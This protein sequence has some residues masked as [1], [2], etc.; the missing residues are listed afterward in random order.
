MADDLWRLDA[1]ALGRLLRRR[2][3]SPVD[4]FEMARGR[5]ERI[6]P[7]LNAFVAL[8]RTA[9]AEAEVSE[10]RHRA[11]GPLGPLDGVPVSIKDNLLAAGMPA[12]WGSRL[13]K[14]FVPGT[15]EAPVANLRA[16]G[17]ILVGKTNVPEFTLEG[18]TANALF[19][20]T[21]NPWNPD[22]TPGGSSGGAVASVAAG[23]VPAAIG[24]DGGGSIR[25]PAGYTGLVGLKPSLGRVR[26]RGGFPPLLL[27]MEVAGGLTRSVRDAKVVFAAMAGLG[28]ASPGNTVVAGAPPPKH[29][30]LYVERFGAAPLDPLIAAACR[31]AAG[32]LS[33][34]GHDVR[35]GR[36]PFDLEP[37]DRVWAEIGQIG[38][39]ALFGRHP[40]ARAKASE[41]YVAMADLGAALPATRPSGILDALRAFRAAAAAAFEAV[42]VVMTPASAAMPWPVSEPYPATIDG[43]AVG[44]RGHAVYTGW[45]NAAGH[46]AIGLPARPAPD[47]T[48][49]GFQLVG[50][51][52]ADAGLLDL[53]AAF[54]AARPWAGRWPTIALGA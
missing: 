48:P 22:L 13:F 52:G 41:K 29:R 4:L 49:I 7:R 20:A 24:T 18:Y 23:L 10:A 51:F 39:A 54:E 17:A 32:A 33:D 38:L 31:D 6:D 15:D 45:V 50:R 46:P 27:D 2:E 47:G 9:R 16:A 19:G 28:R 42:D 3:V 5:I 26:R 8:S 11:G 12:T 35:E 1:R 21:G 37:I 53:A 43:E 30:V 25:R 40:E 34:L 14:D 36:L 44:P